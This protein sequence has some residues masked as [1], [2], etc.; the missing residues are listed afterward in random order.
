MS[1][2]ITG[3]QRELLYEFIT[4]R[5]TGIDSVWRLFGEKE[6]EK[7]RRCGREYADFLLLLDEGLGWEPE[8]DGPAEL[9]VSPAVLDRALEALKVAA[10]VDDEE[11]QELRLLV[12]RTEVRREETIKACDEL[13]ARMDG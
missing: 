1:I 10:L 5:L 9:L 7:A 2:E 11:Q 8:R 4:D 13:Q 3:R 12:A 6:W